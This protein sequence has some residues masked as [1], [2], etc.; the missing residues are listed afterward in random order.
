[1]RQPVSSSKRPKARAGSG[2]EVERRKAEHLRLAASQDVSSRTGPGWADVQLV[3]QALPVADLSAIDLRLEFV[4]HHLQAPLTIAAMTGGHQAASKVNGILAGAA[5]RHG[6]AIGLGSQR[7][8]LRNPALVPTYSVARE[9]APTAF[10]I[11][12]IGA[13]Q[14]VPQAGE[15]PLTRRQLSEAVAMVGADAIAIHLNFLEETVQ[16]EGDRQVAGLRDALRAAVAS[17]P[18]PAIAKETGAGLSRT[19]ALELRRMGFRALDV[20]GVGGTSFAAVEAKRAQAR[21]DLRGASLG[22]V[23]RDWGIP[24]AVSIVGARA[25]GLPIIATG[26]V[27][28]GLDAAKAIALGA[29]LVGVARPLLSAALEGEAA[30]DAWITQFLEE[31]R[32]A[33][34]LSGGRCLDDLR[35]APR[36]ILG[37]TRR[38]IDDL[39]YG[40]QN[41]TPQFALDTSDTRDSALSTPRRGETAG[42]PPI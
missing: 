24:T 32:V 40:L 22:K 42:V 30:V 2:D 10:L 34:F 4:G 9:M 33:I 20:G 19:T 15:A 13:P 16:P 29:S 26:G 8:A 25:A 17:L 39:G 11:A 31:L 7:A 6:L 5:Q 37:D 3:H 35:S 28:T 36:V 27:R 1:M 12:N 21:G 18:V 14:L 41:D 23:Y 38:W